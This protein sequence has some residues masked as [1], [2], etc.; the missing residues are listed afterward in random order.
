MTTEPPSETPQPNPP[1]VSQRARLIRGALGYVIGY[2]AGGLIGW[3]IDRAFTSTP[4]VGVRIG[5]FVGGLCGV[6]LGAG[7]GWR[8]VGIMLSMVICSAAGAGLGLALWY[9]GPNS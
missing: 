6:A 9:P 2:S 4:Y 1:P 8:G 3:L 5:A 7:T